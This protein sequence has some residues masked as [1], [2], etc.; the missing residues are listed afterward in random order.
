MYRFRNIDVSDEEPFDSNQSIN[1]SDGLTIIADDGFSGA[2]TVVNMLRQEFKEANQSDSMLDNAELNMWI[3]FFDNQV[4]PLHGGW[5]WEPLA[6]LIS[7]SEIFTFKRDEF[8]ALVTQNIRKLLSAKIQGLSKFNR[9]VKSP[10]QLY[11]KVNNEGAVR[12]QE[13]ITK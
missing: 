1:F 12:C 7:S 6:S 8:E 4:Y 2:T 10:E 3:F 11:A 13:V 5:P 9:W